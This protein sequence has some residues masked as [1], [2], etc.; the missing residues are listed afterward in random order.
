MP[1]ITVKRMGIFIA[2]LLVSALAMQAFVAFLNSRDLALPGTLAFAQGASSVVEMVG[3]GAQLFVRKSIHYHGV[4]GR[5]EPDTDLR[6]N[7]ARQ[8]RRQ[9]LDFVD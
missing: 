7:L 2:V 4:P 5:Q 1:P 3:R 8:V 6:P 9:C